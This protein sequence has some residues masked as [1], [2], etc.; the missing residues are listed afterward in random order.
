MRIFGTYGP[1]NIKEHYVVSRR[2]EIADYINR[3]KQGRYIVLFA[4]RQTGKTTFFKNAFNTLIDEEIAYFPAQLNFEAYK[5]RPPDLFYTDIFDD[6]REE[7]ETIYEKR[8]LKLSSELVELLDTTKIT[9]N[10]AMR[11]FFRKLPSLLFRE[12][13]PTEV[14][15]IVLNIDEFDGIP[16]SVLS[17]FLH[18]LRRIYLT[19]SYVRSPYSVSI[20]GVKSITQLNYDR[21]ISPFNIQDE[22]TLPNFT[23]LQVQELLAQYTD[24]VGQSFAPEVIEILHKQTAGQPFLVNRLAQ[25]LTD[26]L[27]IPKSDTIKIS[28]FLHAHARLLEERNTNIDHLITNIRRDRRFEKMLMDIAFSDEG[29]RYNLHNEIISE[30]VTYGVITKGED[31]LCKILNPIYLH[32]IIQAFQP[33]AN[34]LEDEY[35]SDDGPMD[36]F[37][38]ITPS[39]SIQ[40]NALIENFKNFIARAGY[41]IL[42]VPD[43]PQEFIGQY[44]LSAYLDQ[45]VQSV[46]ASMRLEVQTGKGRADIIIS[47]N[48]TQY[49]IETKIWRSERRYQAGKQQLAEY[50]KSERTTEG[51]YVVFDHR[52][53]PNPLVETDIYDDLTIRSYVIPVLQKRPSQVL[54]ERQ[55]MYIPNSPQHLETT[56]KPQSSWLPAEPD[57]KTI[58]KTYSNPIY[59]LSQAEIPA[60]ILRNAYSPEQ[61]QGLIN[62]FTNMGL[63]RD[64]ADINSTDKRTRIDIGTS[65]GNRGSD[66]DGFLTHAKE[67]H[68]LFRFLFD[69]F[70]N[71]VDLIYE[72]LSALSPGKEVKV[73]REDDEALYGPAIF[74]VHYETHSYKPH[75]DSVKHREKRTD[76]AVYRFEH[77]FA[78]VLCFQN[79]D[80][81]GKGTQAILH[82]CLWSEDIQPYIAEET[83]DKYALENGIENC[84]VNLEQGDLYF[85]NT[86]CI[87]EVPAVQG[88]RAR[89]VLAVFI[90]YSPDDNEIYVWS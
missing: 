50:L 31:G 84:T 33:L 89:I 41:R 7:I 11:R 59:S 63:M 81:N 74:R 62:R 45:F 52:E 72:S 37:G 14:P 53:N 86:R 71:P 6:I 56:M 70:D 34:G 44:L 47:H 78:G 54:A 27:E 57:L 19:D 39:G 85:F 49:I 76:Y 35:L 8:N 36:F 16:Q 5:N 43:T 55:F 23:L 69:G 77:Q 1:V 2:E 51:Y 68:N 17:D 82:R 3:V 46:G 73:A 12:N 67:T 22:F 90:G 75:I 9:D 87:H 24:E 42:Q 66:K 64:E 40:M 65:L 83:F 21:S 88:T 58:Y 18:T 29:K 20:V 4:P 26:E 28:H 48:G 30:L 15:R 60:I 32:C 10:V 25:I 13:D 80:E 61:C 38:Y 79:A